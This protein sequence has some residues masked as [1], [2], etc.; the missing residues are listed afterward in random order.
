MTRPLPVYRRDGLCWRPANAAASEELL[1]AKPGERVVLT[2]RRPRNLEH[3]NKLFAILGRIVK[4]SGQWHSTEEL[5][6]DLMRALKRGE[7]RTCKLTGAQVWVRERINF[8]SMDQKAF[9][10]L[11]DQI[12]ALLLDNLGFDPEELLTDDERRAA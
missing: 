9:A 2:L 8:E 3:H 1:A 4:G 12:K 11:Y 5:L 6:D 7:Y 10:E